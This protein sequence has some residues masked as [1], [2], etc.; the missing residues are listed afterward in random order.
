MDERSKEFS[1]P[2]VSAS[3]LRCSSSHNYQ[4]PTDISC[5]WVPPDNMQFIPHFQSLCLPHLD[6]LNSPEAHG[7]PTPRDPRHLAPVIGCPLDFFAQ[8]QECC[9][10][11]Q[12][13]KQLDVTESKS[14][15][16]PLRRSHFVSTSSNCCI[17][18]PTC[19]DIGAETKSP[20][21]QNVLSAHSRNFDNLISSK[22]S[23]GED[24][25][26]SADDEDH[27]KTNCEGRDKPG[28]TRTRGKRLL[29]PKNATPLYGKT[30]SW[31][32][33]SSPDN[34][35]APLLGNSKVKVSTSKCS[36]IPS[37]KVSSKSNDQQDL[38]DFSEVQASST[39]GE[40]RRQSTAF[41]VS[42]E[43]SE[44]AA[45][46]SLS[47][48]LP[49]F[50]IN[51]HLCS[52]FPI[53][54]KMS[55]QKREAS[56]RRKQLLEA[57]ERNLSS[58][59]ASEHGTYVIDLDLDD[60]INED[61]FV[62]MAFSQKK[63]ET[64][65]RKCS[66]L[67][68]TACQVQ[69]SNKI[70]IK[71]DKTNRKK[72]DTENKQNPKKVSR[73]KTFV[74]SSEDLEDQLTVKHQDKVTDFRENSVDKLSI[75]KY[76]SST[77]D[78]N[79]FTIP[80]LDKSTKL[81]SSLD[82]RQLSKESSWNF[83][84]SDNI[85]ENMEYTT[86][87]IKLDSPK[88]LSKPTFENKIKDDCCH[89]NRMDSEEYSSSISPINDSL[90]Q[91]TDLFKLND[92]DSNSIQMQDL[93]ESDFNLLTTRS[94]KTELLL[95]P[96][97]E[98]SL[99]L[100]QSRSYSRLN[101][102]KLEDCKEDFPF[103]KAADRMKAGRDESSCESTDS[104]EKLGTM[105]NEIMRPQNI[106]DS[107]CKFEAK[108]NVQNDINDSMKSL[109][110]DSKSVPMGFEEND[111]I[112]KRY[113]NSIATC[114]DSS[115][116]DCQSNFTDLSLGQKIVKKCRS[117]SSAST[118][119]SQESFIPPHRKQT[120]ASIQKLISSN[121]PTAPDKPSYKP[122]TSKQKTIPDAQS[123]GLKQCR[124]S[125]RERS[126]TELS[127]KG[128]SFSGKLV[129]R[130]SDWQLKGRAKQ[131]LENASQVKMEKGND[132]ISSLT[133][134]MKYSAQI[135]LLAGNLLELISLRNEKKDVWISA[136]RQTADTA[137]TSRLSTMLSTMKAS[138]DLLF[139]LHDFLIAEMDQI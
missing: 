17:F 69:D 114:T 139:D 76:T 64:V 67:K 65:Q 6:R 86:S 82:T 19:R 15:P 10:C 122:P 83:M 115:I 1:N 44:Q 81:G 45:Q 129:A 98:I 70:K 63:A 24:P 93:E 27:F 71:E 13:I 127:V 97:E 23:N 75:N 123:K 49:S 66:P 124:S 79:N 131:R 33:D 38:S 102:K 125:I 94:M 113:Q 28:I 32:G 132:D 26:I 101:N 126:S 16:M 14:Q 36:T 116:E 4:L 92:V 110:V 105:S 22:S 77:N 133:A 25:K 54:R 31:W 72:K 108:H 51:D 111:P 128:R 12:H 9:T 89:N 34:S 100:K 60:D 109:R 62:Q 53:S 106:F 84:N 30:P 11:P 58:D 39:D 85:L 3:S 87:I 138:N 80:T 48:S 7:C 112:N 61:D 117:N 40:K 120:Y 52:Y 74:V 56:V 42:L 73:K 57:T 137:V 96:T 18:L 5:C 43:N 55:L 88:I 103:K 29:C 90:S 35:Y 59:A 68:E 50:Q 121:S 119:K 95:K 2:K 99:H 91:V 104:I 47:S 46:M 130:D 20:A 37:S 118:G 78:K 8:K 135:Q 136:G 41:V 107:N 21:C 134:I